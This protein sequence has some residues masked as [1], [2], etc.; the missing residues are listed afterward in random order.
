MSGD[1]L[2]RV[3]TE[4]DTA[5]LK[6]LYILECPDVSEGNCETLQ[7]MFEGRELVVSTLASP[8]EYSE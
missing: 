4:L 3:F 8:V 7:R 6:E 2:I 5:S 1:S